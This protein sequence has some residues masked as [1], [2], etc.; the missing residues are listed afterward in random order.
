MEIE[1]THKLG[2]VL[3]C[4]MLLLHFVGYHFCMEL[5][6]IEMPSLPP[7]Y[8]LQVLNWLCQYYSVH[9]PRLRQHS[10]QVHQVIDSISI[11]FLIQSM[12]F[13]GGSLDT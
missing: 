8:S 12:Y 10:G 2:G 13:D 3:K 1:E 6:P 5:P 7:S 9:V 4:S 11:L